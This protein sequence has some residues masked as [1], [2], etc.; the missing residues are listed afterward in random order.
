MSQKRYALIGHPI[1]HTMS[2]F[3]HSRLFDIKGI[4]AKYD[5]MNI[6][7][8]DIKKNIQILRNLDGY[9]VT[10]PNKQAI[11]H[12]L[13]KLDR[14]AKLH[15]SVNTVRNGKV[16]E[17]FTTDA[18]G[19]L[20]SL[21]F[22][23][24]SLS[25]SIVILGAGGAA[26]TLVYELVEKGLC[27][28]VAVRPTSLL[29]AATLAGEIKKDLINMEINTCLIDRLTGP[30]DLLINA[31][32]AG[33]Y[34]NICESPVSEK[35]IKNCSTVFDLVYNPIET[36]LIKIA[37]ANG[38]KVISGLNMLVFQAV[39]SHEIWDGSIYSNEEIMNLCEETKIELLKTFKN[40]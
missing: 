31:T 18:D 19:F 16:S 27:P 15:G 26:R 34:P 8:K 39:K 28:T 17:G 21:E 20:K 5:I 37:K 7:A 38:S 23:K 2:A 33:M 35:V 9:N 6:S 11:I 29:K 30:I 40:E 12:Y 22:E 1:K 3:I 25:G 36:Q 24:V 14:K 13:D 4:N 10:I 32:P